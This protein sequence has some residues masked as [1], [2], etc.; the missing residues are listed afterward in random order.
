MLSRVVFLTVYI[1]SSAWRMRS[2]ALL[3]SVGEGGNAEGGAD[4]EIDVFAEMELGVAQ[5]VAQA[6]GDDERG[7]LYRFG[8]AGRRTHRRRS[9][10]RSR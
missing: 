7:M 8:E 4:V 6:A 5:Q 10:R 3:A 1:I 2:W 9:G